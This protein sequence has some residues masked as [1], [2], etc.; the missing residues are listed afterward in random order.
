[1]HECPITGE[2]IYPNET[3]SRTAAAQLATLVSDLPN[4]MQEV[5][6]A[7]QG[8]RNGQTPTASVAG[9]RPPINLALLDDIDDMR[10][11]LNTWAAELLHWAAP[12]VRFRN[13]DWHHIRTIIQTYADKAR[14]WTEAPAMAEEIRY[15]IHRLEH[16]ASPKRE[17]TTYAGK[18]PHCAADITT[19]TEGET[20]C[21]TCHNTVDTATTR[22]T[23]LDQLAHKPMTREHARQ[24]AELITGHTI[25]PST[26]RSWAH[27]GHLTPD[28]NGQYTP[29]QI[30]ELATR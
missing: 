25:P 22:Q 13:G 12:T 30:T 1:M 19:R 16:L 18:C 5:A 8:L 27:R 29:H 28:Q 10:D 26:L 9:S 2:P 20:T 15:I 4:L 24:A 7:L 23:M 21:R 17:A 14:T 6:Y 3:I 11:S